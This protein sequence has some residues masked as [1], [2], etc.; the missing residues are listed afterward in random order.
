MTKEFKYDVFMSHN[1]KDK[2][3]VR[4]LAEQLQRAGMRV[5]L[6]EWVIKPGEN[7]VL[8]IERG[9]ETSQTL[10]LCM[11]ESAFKSGWV[12]LER[13]TA[14]FRDP[15]NK[16]RRFIP[17]LLTDCQI[18]EMLSCY[19]Y[20]DFRRWS[21]E[22]FR[23]LI[24]ACEV[25]VVRPVQPVLPPL[26]DWLNLSKREWK[27]SPGALLRADHAIVPFHGREEELDIYKRWVMDDKT[28]V[29]RLLTGSGGMG[30]TRFARELCLQVQQEGI[31]SGFLD[32]AEIESC[33]F[34]LKSGLIGKSLVVID[35]AESAE[36]VIEEILRIVIKGGMTSFRLLLLARGA[37][38][39]WAKLKRTGNGIGECIRHDP[40]K[41]KPLTLDTEG[42][43]NSYRLARKS[44]AEVLEKTDPDYEPKDFSIPEYN[45]ILLLHMSA[46]LAI[47]DIQAKG[48]DNII[49]KILSREISNWEKQVKSHQLP[50]TLVD[51]FDRAMGIISACGGVSDKNEAIELIRQIRFFQDIRISEVETIVEILHNSFPGTNWIEPI[52]P[53]LLMEYLIAKITKEYPYD[54]INIL[55]P[56]NME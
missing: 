18:P 12:G 44:F 11:S 28:F 54:I 3:R 53:D 1:S 15:N 30:K 8:A 14:I 48:M 38:Q 39:W 9:L 23:E 21:S 27:G 22:A 5:W 37:G 51:G 56:K 42:R 36:E 25:D 34:D 55:L 45:R 4:Q 41:L 29:A 24:V 49:E 31:I 26:P 47:D 2:P 52:Q 13:S 43:R 17:L 32:I 20:I 35:Y 10:I 7:I 33:R 46:L 50:P 6:D 40:H 16:Y 19:K